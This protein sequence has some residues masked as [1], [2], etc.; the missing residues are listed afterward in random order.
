MSVQVE[1]LEEKNTVKLTVEVSAEELEKAL[2]EAYNKQKKDISI[3]GFR[4]GKVP[5]MMIEKMFG[6]DVFYEDAVNS[7]LPQAYSDAAKESG[8]DIVSRPVIDVVQIEKGKPFIFTAE[9]AIKPEVTLG[10]YMGVTVTKADTT[11]TDEEIDKAVDQERENNA[12]IVAVEGR[13]IESGDTAVID[14]EGFVDGVAFD[15]G[16]AENHSLV[17]GSGSFIPGFEDQLIGKNAGEDVEINVTFPEEYHSEDLAGKDAVF[18]VKIHEIKTKEIPE[19]DDE[20]AQDVS[21]FDT[22]A[23]YRDSV[24]KKLEERKE[25]EVKNAQQQEALDKII[26]KSQ[27]DIPAAMIDT[28]CENMINNFA[29]QMAQQGLSMDQYMQFSGTTMDQL[30]EQVRPEAE[31]RIKQ[32]LVLEAI[33]KAENIEITDEDVDAEIEKMAAMYQMEAEQLKDY[34][35]EEEKENMKLDLAS[36]KAMELIAENMKPRAKAKSKKEKEE[37]VAAEAESTEEAA[38]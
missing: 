1:N 18:K 29:Q 21:E 19:L 12:R 17:I 23:E 13:A 28:Q 16:K 5:R 27:M 26:E 11:V 37:E 4:K 35:G 3:P 2:Q 14:Y 33:A 6:P 15:G 30:K 7:L 31:G 20:F 38:E 32:E 8:Q 36:R 34:M 25:A 10:K 22:V 24:K 9:V